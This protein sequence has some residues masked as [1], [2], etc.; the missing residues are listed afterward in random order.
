MSIVSQS[1]LNHRLDVEKGKGK[2]D[3]NAEQNIKRTQKK[4]PNRSKQTKISKHYPPTHTAATASAG[5]Q[6]DEK[7]NRALN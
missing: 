1:I 4:I 7:F 2:N 6:V 3:Q 5:W